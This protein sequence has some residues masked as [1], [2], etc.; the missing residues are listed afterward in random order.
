MQ[1]TIKILISFTGRKLQE[2]DIKKRKTGITNHCFLTRLKVTRVAVEIS[3]LFGFGVL[4]PSEDL[5]A[6]AKP[7]PEF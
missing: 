4:G 5:K 2:C 3:I 1:T 7:Q 6:V